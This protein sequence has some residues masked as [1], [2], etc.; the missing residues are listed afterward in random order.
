V[1]VL[2]SSAGRRVSLVHI[3]REALAQSD[4]EPRVLA[5]DASQLAAAWH[6]ADGAFLVPPCEDKSFIPE[7]V[8]LCR[9]ERVRLLVPT[10][11]T[12]LPK[13]SA[14]H[15]LFREVGTLLAISSEATVAVTADKRRT[16]AWMVGAGIPTVEQGEVEA[17][18]AA[19]WPFPLVV[20][21][22][23]GSASL[24]VHVVTDRASFDVAVREGDT[25]VQAMASGVEFTIDCLVDDDGH[26]V[27]AVPRRRLAVRAG[28]VSK[29]VTVDL[30][31]LSSIAEQVCSALPGPFGVL[32]VQVFH[33]VQTGRSQVIEV[34]PRFG[35]GFP[36][37]HRAGAPFARWLVERAWGRKPELNMS[38]LPGLTMLRYDEA[39]YVLPEPGEGP[40][41]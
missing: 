3:F 9:R 17:V 15:D 38:W 19:R 24:G 26:L 10:I 1:S 36:L 29:S 20:K 16:H 28:E 6:A 41:L 5:S 13:L 32:N 7:L 40:P 2:I 12:E 27:A 8:D 23:Y 39:V 22:V 31:A 25:I 34:N 30:P 35:G 4:L 33:D 21:P 37:S 14:A 18:R 11:D